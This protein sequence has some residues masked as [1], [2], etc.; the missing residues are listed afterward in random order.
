MD[1]LIQAQTEAVT[2]KMTKMVKKERNQWIKTNHQLMPD[3]QNM[4]AVLK[5]IQNQLN[6]KMKTNTATMNL[7]GQPIKIM[8]Q[9][10]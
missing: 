10:H 1:H 2:M 8:V 9:N 7:S 5:T 6:L 3:H 4:A